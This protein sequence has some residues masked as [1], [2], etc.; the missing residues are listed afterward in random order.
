ARGRAPEPLQG[1]RIVQVDMTA[2][3]AGSKYR[4]D[5]EER[6]QGVIR[7]ASQSADIILF[8][9]EIHTVMGAGRAEGV[10][11]DAANILKPALAR[12]DLRLI[13]ATTEEEYRRYIEKDSAL[14]RR[15]QPIPVREPS[16]EETLEILQGIRLRLEE[17]HGVK[18]EDGALRAAVQLS[19][20]Y[21]PDRRLPDKAIDLLEEAC[22][23]GVVQWPSALPGEEPPPGEPGVITAEDVA[24]V[25][26]RLTGIPAAQLRED[27]RQRLQEMAAELKKRVIGQD[28]ACDAVAEAVQKARLGLKEAGRPVGVFLFLGPTGV[29][30][31]ELAR[32]TAAFLFGSEKAMVRLDMSEYQGPH[33]VARLIGAPPGYVGHG[34][35]GQLTGPLR[36]TPYCVVLVDE[37]EKAHPEVLNLFLQLFD[38][39]RLTDAKGKTADATNALFILTSNLKMEEEPQMGF[40]ARGGSNV[41]KLIVEGGLKPELVNRLDEVI[42]FRPLEE[43]HLQRIAANLLERFRQRLLPQDIDLQWDKKVPAYLAKQGYSE[44]FGARELRRVIEQQVENQIAGKM[45][46]GELGA[47]QIVRLTVKKEALIMQIEGDPNATN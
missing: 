25:V 33:T 24:Q 1:K 8:I 35:E 4:G 23:A 3:T 46:R 17:H 29:G 45:L 32:A 18:I 42:V 19:V 41:R 37:I 38:E 30:K 16:P 15:F 44:Q 21:L 9:D 22:A 14:E 36:N 47:G 43:S 12:G 20:K 13:G 11:M 5:F 10:V 2:L 6:I 31:T 26:S 40:R 34:E 27:E 7:E 28:E 39:G